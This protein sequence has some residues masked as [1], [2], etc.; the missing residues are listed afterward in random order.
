MTDLEFA[1]QISNSAEEIPL[2]LH[3]SNTKGVKNE[4]IS[5]NYKL[6]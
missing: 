2:Q 5:I 6:L 1:Y 3:P 4:N